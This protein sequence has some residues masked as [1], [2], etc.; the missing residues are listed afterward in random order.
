MRRK[1]KKINLIMA[2]LTLGILLSCSSGSSA[3]SSSTSKEDST[4]N[5]SS[6]SSISSSTSSVEHSSS[7][8]SS[9]SSSSSSLTSSIGES[10]SSK[11]DKQE[12]IEKE[13]LKV[14]ITLD[15]SSLYLDETNAEKLLVSGFNKDKYRITLSEEK[16]LEKDTFI[17]TYFLSTL[18]GSIVSSSLKASF[19]GF[20]KDDYDLSKILR[21]EGLSQGE[22]KN[23]GS[24]FE[25]SLSLTKE[26]HY[27][28]EINVESSG[29]SV[30][31]ATISFTKDNW[32]TTKY[33]LINAYHDTSSFANGE[34]N[35]AFK[36]GEKSLLSLS[37]VVANIDKK[38]N[39]TFLSDE[40]L[41]IDN[42]SSSTF[43]FSIGKETENDTVV[44]FVPCF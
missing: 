1:V 36:R 39:N 3:L 18:D 14:S 16:D 22:S 32:N 6:S 15:A 4:S 23:E 28:L 5:S 27:P 8:F 29:C 41:I 25:I 13:L 42:H 19:A 24:S 37:F 30:N 44:S 17:V 9:S 2:P 20:K 35:I 12:A 34:G 43:S 10:S 31:T 33:I 7:P 26:I 21:V 40:S 11:E 38:E